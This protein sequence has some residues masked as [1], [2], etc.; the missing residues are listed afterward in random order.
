MFEGKQLLDTINYPFIFD[1]FKR[2][3]TLHKLLHILLLANI[4]L[5]LKYL[6]KTK[7]YGRVFR[8]NR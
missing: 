8:K 1:E 7:I 6:L 4:L 3:E 5:W 2:L